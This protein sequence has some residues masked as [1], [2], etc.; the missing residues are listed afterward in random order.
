MQS[1]RREFASL[2]SEGV[3]AEPDPTPWAARRRRDILFGESYP[4]WLQR[5]CDSIRTA[6]DLIYRL[7]PLK[8][9]KVLSQSRANNAGAEASEALDDRSG[10]CGIGGTASP[11]SLIGAYAHG[12]YPRSFFGTFSWWSPP[13]RT[14][15][16]PDQLEISSEIDALVVGSGL[17]VTLDRDFDGMVAACSR[18]FRSAAL[19]SAI[20]KHR[21]A[22][23]PL[24]PDHRH[25]LAVVYDLGIAHSFEVWD[26]R[27]LLIA[28][29]YGISVGAVFVCEGLFA[30]TEEAAFAGV[31]LLNRYLAE[32]RYAFFDLKTYA[33]I[34]LPLTVLDRRA[35]RRLLAEHLAG[36]RYGRWRTAAQD[37]GSQDVGSQGVGSQK[38][39]SK[40]A[41]KAPSANG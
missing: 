21:P 16:I 29:G 17:R 26:A 33:P 3:T 4:L 31:M 13:T 32:W 10:F 36:G 39:V 20:G 15:V 6:V 18:P 2:F 27:N 40:A 12:R 5:Q 23:P 24:A 41:L 11:K 8:F 1:C 14:G 38:Y 35:Y 37:V 25:L 7:G 30:Q 9:S 19:T 22:L 34:G 28:G